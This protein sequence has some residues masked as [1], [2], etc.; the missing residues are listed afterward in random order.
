MF[1]RN[2]CIAAGNSGDTS[3]L[4]PLEALRSRPELA[5]YVAWALDRL[6]GANGLDP[7]PGPGV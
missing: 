7:A 2:A 5:R 6:G 4:G 3:L 1:L